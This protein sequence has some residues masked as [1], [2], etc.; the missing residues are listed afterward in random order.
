MQPVRL[1]CGG[2]RKIDDSRLHDC[3]SLHGID[4]QDFV[5][6]IQCDDD[7]SRDRQ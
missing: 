3:D 7:S 4:A 1:G 5:E 6:T 2:D